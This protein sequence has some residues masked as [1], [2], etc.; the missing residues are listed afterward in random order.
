[1]ASMSNPLRREGIPRKV[2]IQTFGCHMN[3][4]DTDKMFEVLRGE[5][6][7]KA[8]S[9]EE[10]D[11]I[12]LNTCCVREK[13]EQKVY[14]QLGRLRGLKKKNPGLKI[15]VGG[16]VAQQEGTRLLQIAQNVDFV[17]GTDTLFELPEML[18]ET[19]LGNK[20]VR[21]E[22]KTS[23]EKVYNLIPESQSFH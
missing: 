5:D 3:E 17:F 2:Y 4:Y 10:T 19:E 13:A 12:L 22:R 7:Q 21:I 18:R 11:L 16:C 14:S 8:L 6:Y 1:M 15:G 9:P 20:S 23:R